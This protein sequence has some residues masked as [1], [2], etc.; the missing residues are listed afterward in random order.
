M[1][2]DLH[3]HGRSI[4]AGVLIDDNPSYALECAEAGMPVLLY[5]W[6][7]EYPW[8]KMPHG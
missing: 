1:K 4:G 3:E 2:D 5:D 6:K 7:E 8:S